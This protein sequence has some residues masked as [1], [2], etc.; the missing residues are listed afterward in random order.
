MRK[1]FVV[2]FLSARRVRAAEYAREAEV[3]YIRPVM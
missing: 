2:E 1:L 3:G